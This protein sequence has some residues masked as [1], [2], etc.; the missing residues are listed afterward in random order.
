[1]KWHINGTNYVVNKFPGTS[2]GTPKMWQLGSTPFALL[3]AK[4]WQLSE[5]PVVSEQAP[6]SNEV[7]VTELERNFIDLCYSGLNCN[8]SE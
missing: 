2:Y 5:F 3:A 1:M 8:A 6:C 4:P 7:Y